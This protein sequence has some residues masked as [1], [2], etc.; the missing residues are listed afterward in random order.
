MKICIIG[1]SGHVNYVLEDIKKR[2]DIKIEAIAPGPGEEAVQGLCEKLK[3]LGF[4]RNEWMGLG[5]D[6][7]CP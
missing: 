2:P 4:G 7:P 5:L 3:T 6:A 1:S